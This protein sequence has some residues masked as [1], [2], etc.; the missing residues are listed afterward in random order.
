MEQKNIIEI[1]FTSEYKV[2]DLNWE[3]LS[4]KNFCMTS[5]WDDTVLLISDT[6]THE[7]LKGYY[8]LLED[9]IDAATANGKDAWEEAEVPESD[10]Q[11]YLFDAVAVSIK[12]V[13]S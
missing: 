2:Y 13:N 12:L 7:E 6:L 8:N 3:Y 10:Y 11:V 5:F 4:G 9:M 1:G